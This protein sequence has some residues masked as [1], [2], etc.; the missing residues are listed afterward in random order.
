MDYQ[1]LFSERAAA[2]KTSPITELF[3]LIQTKPDLIS[4]APGTPDI[5]VLPLEMVEPLTKQALQKYGRPILQ[6]GL[7]QGFEPLRQAVLPL[8]AKRGITE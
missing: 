8:L 1:R 4:F 6:Y 2:T 5:N 7:P 3:K